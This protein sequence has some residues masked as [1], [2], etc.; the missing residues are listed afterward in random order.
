MTLNVTQGQLNCRYSTGHI[1]LPVSNNDSILHHFL[2]IT[3]LTLHTTT[4]D[5]LRP[6][7]L[8]TSIWWC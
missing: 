2:D 8:K 1:S 7:F 3:T 6:S 4:Y 5:L